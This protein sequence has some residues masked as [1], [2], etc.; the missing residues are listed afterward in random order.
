MELACELE[1]SI[2]KKEAL[3]LKSAFEELRHVKIVEL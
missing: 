2:R 1:V 3:K